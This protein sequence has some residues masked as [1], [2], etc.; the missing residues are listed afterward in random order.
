MVWCKILTTQRITTKKI[1]T[2]MVVTR[3]LFTIGEKT[4]TQQIDNKNGI[5]NLE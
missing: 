3:P 4:T 2:V 1:T 5:L